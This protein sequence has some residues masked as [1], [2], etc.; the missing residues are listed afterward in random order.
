M[1]LSDHTRSS[2]AFRVGD[3]LCIA[4]EVARE[5]GLMVTSFIG[6]SLILLG[7]SCGWARSAHGGLGTDGRRLL[8]LLLLILDR[9]FIGGCCRFAGPF[10]TVRG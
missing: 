7:P 1:P 9:L 5:V 2:S 4:T 3:Y 10:N 8:D 6:N